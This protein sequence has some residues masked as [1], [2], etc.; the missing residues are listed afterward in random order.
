MPALNGKSEVGTT[1]ISLLGCP[2]EALGSV[3]AVEEALQGIVERGTGGLVMAIN[4][5]KIFRYSN[6]RR[7]KAAADSAVLPY[8]DGFGAVLAAKVLYGVRLF[9]VPMF[10]LLLDLAEKNRYRVFLYGAS[11]ESNAKAFNIAKERYPNIQL[12]GR[13]NGYEKDEARVADALRSARPDIVFIALGSPRQEETANRLYK[14]LPWIVFSGS[15]GAFDVLAGTVER[16]PIWYQDHNLE[17]FYRLMKQPSRII[18]QI[19]LPIFLS[20]LIDAA[21]ANAFKR[22]A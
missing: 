19:A 3:G 16:A 11:E 17:W 14:E 20:R 18:R 12:V 1:R 6:N 5:E 22:G 21:I 2:C 10:Y 4:A 8:A 13:M 7:L 15:G 9:R